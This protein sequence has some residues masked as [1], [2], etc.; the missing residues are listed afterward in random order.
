MQQNLFHLG[1]R[2]TRKIARVNRA[3]AW[4]VRRRRKIIQKVTQGI[5][6]KNIVFRIAT[7]RIRQH[8]A[9]FNGIDGSERGFK[10]LGR[11]HQIRYLVAAAMKNSVVV[12]GAGANSS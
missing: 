9:V 5:V 7:S 12:G 1:R 6:I 4:P 11:T 8:S 3:L 10:H 2:H